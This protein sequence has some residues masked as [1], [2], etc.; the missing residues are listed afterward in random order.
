MKLLLDHEG[1][2]NIRVMS[3][4]TAI[5]SEDIISTLQSLNMIKYWKGQHVIA[6]N[7]AI[8]SEALA[9]TSRIKLCK[10]DCLS[11]PVRLKEEAPTVS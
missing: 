11:W 8:I 4:E 6:A 2:L 9:K 3:A 10:P 1:D 7:R 5:K